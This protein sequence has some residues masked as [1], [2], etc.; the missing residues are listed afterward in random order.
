MKQGR[1]KGGK[2]AQKSESPRLVRAMRLTDSAWQTLGEVATLR[3]IT[4]ADLVEEWASHGC[5]QPA[6]QLSLFDQALL[7]PPSLEV[8]TK[9]TRKTGAELARR[10]NVTQAA[11]APYIK[12]LEKFSQWSRKR[13]PDGI[14]WSRL[15]DKKYYPLL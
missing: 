10:L 4:R 9:E 1:D 13:D 5:V 3:G 8:V 6:T 14:S 15:P 7:E 12:N 2:F 11:F